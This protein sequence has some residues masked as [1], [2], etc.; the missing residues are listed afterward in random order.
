MKSHNPA[1]G[2]L[3]REPQFTFEGI[4]RQ[5]LKECFMISYGFL[6]LVT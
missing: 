6:I 4:L 5:G 1:K 3:L 2:L